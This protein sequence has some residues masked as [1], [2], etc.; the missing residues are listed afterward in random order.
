MDISVFNTEDGNVMHELIRH[1]MNKNANLEKK[2]KEDSETIRNLEDK[3]QKANITILKLLEAIIRFN[4]SEHDSCTDIQEYVNPVIL[5]YA[6]GQE[7]DVKYMTDKYLK[8]QET[9]KSLQYDIQRL[10]V[11][12]NYHDNGSTPSGQ[13]T[14][15]QMQQKA[16]RKEKNA[17][18]EPKKPGAPVGTPG[19]SRKWNFESVERLYLS[20]CPECG[21]PLCTIHSYNKGMLRLI[22]NR[23]H[24]IMYVVYKYTCKKGHNVSSKPDW[25]IDGTCMDHTLLSKVIRYRRN[26]STLTGI[27]ED[28]GIAWEDCPISKAAVINAI[29]ATSPKLLKEYNRIGD[30]LKEADTAGIDETTSPIEDKLGYIW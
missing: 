7:M 13:P 26:H 2:H 19:S 28:M 16:E 4:E 8:A 24:E 12:D 18:R 17:E 14:I 25:M 1:T 3:M 10:K 29:R 5:E 6:R 22:D 11:R 9:I 27:C 23:I 21:A 15:T 30:S 20:A